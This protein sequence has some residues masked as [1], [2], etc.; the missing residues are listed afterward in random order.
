MTPEGSEPLPSRSFD[1]PT[2]TVSPDHG[3]A[4]A[5]RDFPMGVN[6][7]SYGSSLRLP[8]ERCLYVSLQTREG[9]EY[10]TAPTNPG[11]KPEP[12]DSR[13][14]VARPSRMLDPTLSV[15]GDTR[16]PQYA[17]S[18]AGLRHVP[19]GL[20]IHRFELCMSRGWDATSTYTSP[21]IG[22]PLVLTHSLP[23][24]GPSPSSEA[25]VGPM[26]GLPVIS[27]SSTIPTPVLEGR[28]FRLP[29]LPPL[30][31]A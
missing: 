24:F 1:P 13:Q 16:E 14:T 20:Q 6:P 27:W 12:D 22:F 10:D 31:V 2:T 23:G 25:T 5:V 18:L 7:C 19:H 21:L 30:R 11:A 4:N 8:L 3:N 15:L 29:A 28:S 9:P 26:K 17:P